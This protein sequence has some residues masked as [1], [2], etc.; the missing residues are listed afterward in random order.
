MSA[1]GAGRR[2]AFTLVELI[3][4]IGILSVLIGVGVGL[5]ARIQVGDRAAVGTVQSVLR[6]ARNWSVARDAPARVRID[7][8]G[9]TIQAFG[10]TVVGTWHFEDLPIRGAFGS[11]G[12]SLG[13]RIVP[14][15]FTGSALSFAGEPA[16]SRVEI[17]V[18]LDPA[19]DLARG[20]SIRCVVRLAGGAGGELLAIGASAGLAVGEDGAVRA[21][22]APAIVTDDGE[23]RRGGRLGLSTQG[24]LLRAGRWS[25]V[26]VQYDRARLAI[27]VDGALAAHLVETAEVWDVEGPLVLSPSGAAFPGA[28]DALVVAAVTGEERRAL[29]RGVEFAPGGPTEI[30]FAAGGGL[31]RSVHQEPVRLALRLGDGREERILVNLHGTVE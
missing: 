19:F 12:V 24:G 25:E 20:F 6:S 2:A 1:R 15:G 26:E 30:V 17:P 22:F 13:G 10:A 8:Q 23:R 21:W 14:D 18:Q 3:I 29:P 31:D 11:E 16:R 9:S 27:L 28:I 7:A 5:V 4:V